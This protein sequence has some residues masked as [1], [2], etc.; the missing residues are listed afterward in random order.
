MDKR[1]CGALITIIIVIVIIIIIIIIRTR[2]V[3]PTSS[4]FW[5]G[6]L[7]KINRDSR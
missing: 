1:I 6:A 4:F 2:F 3:L 7:N 5:S